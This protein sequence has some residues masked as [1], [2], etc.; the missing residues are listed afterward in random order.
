MSLYLRKSLFLIFILVVSIYGTI[1]IAENIEDEQRNCLHKLAETTIDVLI[2]TRNV[3]AKNQELIN[4]D[5]ISGNYYFKGF[6][7]AVV[8]SQ[9]ANDFSLMTGHK[10][11]QTSLKI[12]NP[13][14]APDEWE[15]KK[16]KIMG[17]SK[18]SKDLGFGEFV[19]REG[20]KVYRYIKPIYTEKACLE[21]HGERKDIK[22]AIRQFLEMRYPYD[23]AFGYKEGDFRGG[24]SI[25]I[26][27]ERFGITT[28]QPPMHK[29]TNIED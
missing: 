10:L 14:N 9:V 22:P 7:P 18:Y 12:R 20:K 17:S 2:A 19:E 21:C 16:L 25:I 8:G 3:I 5:P 6:V 26:S 15:R 28:T 11:K 13:Q 24:I 29:N 23:E 4:R 1:G 27:L